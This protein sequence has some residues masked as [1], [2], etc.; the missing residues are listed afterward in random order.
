MVNF[1]SPLMRIVSL[2]GGHGVEGGSEGEGE[3]PER[4]HRHFEH[5]A[6]GKAGWNVR[7]DE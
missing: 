4:Q 5:G 1:L 3:L 7:I 2:G 6:F